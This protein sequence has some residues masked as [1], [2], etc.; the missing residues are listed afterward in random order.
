M[1][2]VVL[3]DVQINQLPIENYNFLISQPKHMLSVLKRTFSMRCFSLYKKKLKLME[4][5]IFTLLCSKIKLAG[6]ILFF[7][8]GF[9]QVLPY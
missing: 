4:K 5:K 8:T 1:C 9:P 7:S 2:G 3:S 6:L